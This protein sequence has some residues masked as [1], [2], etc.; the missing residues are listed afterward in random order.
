MRNDGKAYT[1]ID[2]MGFNVILS[3]HLKINE[4]SEIKAK[5]WCK[6]I[7]DVLSYLHNIGIAFGHN[8]NIDNVL[9]DKKEN[10]KLFGRE[11]FRL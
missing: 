7:A 6:S 10:L 11:L 8:F 5:I 1:F 2:L 9:I 3:N 4:V